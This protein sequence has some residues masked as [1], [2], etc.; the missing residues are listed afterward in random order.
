MSERAPTVVTFV[1]GPSLL[2]DGAV[3]RHARVLS[4]QGLL[5]VREPEN[6][7]DRMAVR[8]ETEDGPVGYLASPDCAQ[9]AVHIDA[10]WVYTCVCVQ[11]PAVLTV[12]R[13]RYVQPDTLIVRCVPIAPLRSAR[14]RTRARE[15]AL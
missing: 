2:G 4:G 10:G 12:R 15:T 8:V 9:V 3:R 6:P 14:T 13:R 11:A 1:R 5:L 7:V